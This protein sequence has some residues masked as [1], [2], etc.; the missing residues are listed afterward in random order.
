MKR[1]HLV[2]AAVCAAFLAPWVMPAKALWDVVAPGLIK[3]GPYLVAGASQYALAS[4]TLT[5]LTVPNGATV[6]QICVETAGVRYRD[7]GTA[8]TSTVGMPVASGTC[9]QYA[10][11]LSVV[12]FI[13]Q[14][15]APTL[16]V[17]YYK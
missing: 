11:P 2:A 3:S 7:D 13:A 10:G 1:V 15:G 16:D 4:T 8:P 6:A 17:A 5:S 12:Q 9:F 14:T